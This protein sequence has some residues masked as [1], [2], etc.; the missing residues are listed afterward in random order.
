MN[1]T[2]HYR[3]DGER[4]LLDPLPEATGRAFVHRVYSGDICDPL[5]FGKWFGP[6]FPRFVIRAY[7]DKP[8][9]HFWAWRYP[10]WIPF[11]GGKCGYAGFKCYGVH[12]EEYTRWPT[13]LNPA[14]VYFGSMALCLSFRPFAAME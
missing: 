1:V 8:K 2:C 11:I 9:L 6:E 14:D 3:N 12:H 7:T 5:F 4:P 13:G 10:A